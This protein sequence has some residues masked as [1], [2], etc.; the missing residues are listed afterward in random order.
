MKL[1]HKGHGAVIEGDFT[2]DGTDYKESTVLGYSLY[3]KSQWG[4]VQE[5]KDVTSE[6]KWVKHPCGEYDSRWVNDWYLEHRGTRVEG[7]PERYRLRQV[8]VQFTP[9]SP[10]EWAFIV[11]KRID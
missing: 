10:F 8:R 6:C 3:H 1:K 2:F 5:W 11:E 7:C 9:T 4:E